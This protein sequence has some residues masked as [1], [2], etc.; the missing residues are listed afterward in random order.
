M[1]NKRVQTL[2][3]CWL[4]AFLAVIDNEG[5]EAKAAD[6][7]GVS[8]SMMNRY[9]GELAAW[10]RTPLFDGNI[11]RELTQYGYTFASTARNVVVS[12]NDARM[13]LPPLDAL[14]P[15]RRSG[16]HIKINRSPSAA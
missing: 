16:K 1:S 10:V 13:P 11:P 8:P 4:E 15:A 2:R 12:L 3:L 7:M 9:I 14:R 5:V 6:A